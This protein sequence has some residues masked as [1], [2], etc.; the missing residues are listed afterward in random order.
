MDK[1]IMGNIMCHSA[2]RKQTNL[3]LAALRCGQPSHTYMYRMNLV[4]VQ[5]N[6]TVQ[7]YHNY[8]LRQ[9]VPT[10]MQNINIIY[11][12]G[13]CNA[14]RHTARFTTSYL[15][16]NSIYVLHVP[17]PDKSPDLN[18]IEHLQLA[19]ASQCVI[20]WV[21]DTKLFW[22]LMVCWPFKILIFNLGVSCLRK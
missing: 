13:A 14:R 11:Q 6:L 7:R 16:S 1:G 10:I 5:S 20:C 12:H 19:Q 3:A 4:H 9:H 8:I 15:R 21:K 17:W 18:P 2:Q 22:I